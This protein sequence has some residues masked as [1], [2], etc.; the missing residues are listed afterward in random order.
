MNDL[1]KIGSPKVELQG[2]R[3]LLIAPINDCG[4]EKYLSYSVDKKYAKYLVQER[5][6]AF[7]TAL[8][9]YAMIKRLNIEW[10]TPCDEQLI[11][12]LKTYFMPIY[13][14]E[15]PF[16]H[17]IELI[18]KVTTEQLESAGGVATGLSNGV[19]STYTVKKYLNKIIKTYK[20]THVLFTDC[21][22]TDNSLQYQEDYLKNYLGTLPDCAKE[23]GLEFIF[24]QFHPDVE[25]SIGHINDKKRGVIQD[26]GLFTLKY[27]SMAMALK[28]LINIYY[29]SG[30]LSPSDFSFRE[31]D[32]AYHDIF[33]LP[34]ISTKEQ[35]FY[36]TGMEVSRLK[37]VE[38]IA[39]WE[40]AQKHLQVCAWDNDKNCGHCS[41]CLRTMSELDAIGKLD[42]F[43][44]RFPV[45]DYRKN[46]A[47]RM[48][49]V[50]MEARKGH[51][52]EIDVLNKMQNKGKH[53]PFSSNFWCVR[54]LFIE[55]LRVRLRTLKWARKI[56]RKYHLDQKLYGRSTVAYSQSIDKEILGK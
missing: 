22:T 17:Q 53:I 8:F 34:L 5:S 10:E 46:Y 15:F 21:F 50:K 19:D 14:S 3:A 29:F 40:Y 48:G 52:F 44:Q 47:K 18:G 41:K 33:T 27:C 24:V 1:L 32:M 31:N 45:R 56:Y 12:Q 49:Y 38:Y 30:G 20:L 11:Y 51:I 6:D 36:S 42:L 4:T 54:Y 43:S 39:D 35:W 13:I 16:M 2:G 26:V 28:K 9:Y 55:Y 37:K 7:V 23:L 25:F